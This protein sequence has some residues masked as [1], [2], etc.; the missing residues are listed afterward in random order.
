MFPAVPTPTLDPRKIPIKVK[1]IPG[2]GVKGVGADA[3][4]RGEC[5]A[6]GEPAL[7]AEALVELAPADELAVE[8]NAGATRA[9][10]EESSDGQEL[11][12]ALCRS[13]C[14]SPCWRM[15]EYHEVC[16]RRIVHQQEEKTVSVALRN[17]RLF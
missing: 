9:V 5:A 3:Q 16:S 11:G 12:E 10:E 8:P 7:T 17:P 2:Y 15:L 14:W 1:V 6:L 13:P 4:E